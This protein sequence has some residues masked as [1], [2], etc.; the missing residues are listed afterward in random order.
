M[1]LILTPSIVKVRL[2]KSKKC[3]LVVKKCFF[4]LTVLNFEITSN[5]LNMKVKKLDIHLDF[6]KF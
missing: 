3:H 4:A 6:K 1:K 2:F 5:C